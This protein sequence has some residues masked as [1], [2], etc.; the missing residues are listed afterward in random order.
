[1][2]TRLLLIMCEGKT[3]KEYFEILRWAFRPPAHIDPMIFGEKGQH[4]P[5]IDKTVEKR[6]EIAAE[7]VLDESEIEAWAVCDDDRMTCSYQDLLKYAEDQNVN[8][9]FSKPQFEYFLLQHFEPCK[10]AKREMIFAK[11]G[12]YRGQ[13]GEDPIYDNCTKAHLNWMQ[14]AIENKPAIVRTAITNS[15]LRNSPQGKTFLTVQRLAERFLEL[16]VK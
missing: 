11:L 4:K 2:A 14:Q 16:E 9:A 5:L 15:D 13:H 10:D 1:M 12:H 8:L 7:L 6:S 3:E